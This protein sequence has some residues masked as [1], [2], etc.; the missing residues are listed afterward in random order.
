MRVDMGLLPHFDFPEEYHFGSHTLVICGYDG[1]NQVLISDMDQA[2]SGLKGGLYAAMTLDEMGHAR[3]STFKPFPPKNTYFEFDFAGARPPGKEDILSAI[4]QNTENMLHPPISN[5]GIKGIR[6]AAKEIV[7]WPD[8]FAE[9]E[10]RA[11]L[12]MIYIMV[13]IGGTGGGIFRPLYGR[14]LQEAA[15]ITEIDAL[16]QSASLLVKS[17]ALFSEMARLFEKML[18][19]DAVGGKIE[20]AAEMLLSSADLEEEAFSI[21]ETVV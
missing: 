4:R 6:R 14:F 21:L 11:N 8:R 1:Q 16:H 12:F 9:A 17:G 13:E 3:G 5:F 2:A 20:E 19:G 18:Q 15:P 7:R 10:L